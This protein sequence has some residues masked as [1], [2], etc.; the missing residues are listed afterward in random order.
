MTRAVLMC[1]AALPWLLL[2]SGSSL[3]LPW[4][5]EA[6]ASVSAVSRLHDAST[7]ELRAV[8]QWWNG[9]REPALT[10]ETWPEPEIDMDECLA[11]YQDAKHGE[12]CVISI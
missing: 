7:V 10:L 8:L 4:G 2:I 9:R 1:V 3:R 5:H 6:K 11:H 12:V